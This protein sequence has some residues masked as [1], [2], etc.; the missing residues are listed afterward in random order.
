MAFQM[1]CSRQKAQKLIKNLFYLN[2]WEEYRLEF[3]IFKHLY[4]SKNNELVLEVAENNSM[5]YLIAISH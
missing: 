3:H 1:H 4:G 5:I 2:W